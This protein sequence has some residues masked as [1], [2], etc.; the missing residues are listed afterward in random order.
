MNKSFPTTG[1]AGPARPSRPRRADRRAGALRRRVR[2]LHDLG[3]LGIARQRRARRPRA[4]RRPARPS[5]SSSA[6]PTDRVSPAN[7]AYPAPADR[8]ATGATNAAPEASER[9]ARRPRI[10]DRPSD[11]ACG[12]PAVS[13][14]ATAPPPATFRRNDS[15]H[16]PPERSG[17]GGAM[18]FA[19]T[20]GGFAGCRLLAVGV[21]SGRLSRRAAKGP[22]AA[23]GNP[24]RSR[25]TR[26][27]PA[28]SS[29]PTRPISTRRNWRSS[30]AICPT[31]SS[32]ACASR[33]SRSPKSI[34]ALIDELSPKLEA[35]K[36]RLN[37]LGPK[38]KDGQPEESADVAGTG[39]SGKPRSP[40]STR[41]SAS[42]ARSS[43]RPS[44]S[45][46][47]ISDRRRAVFTR[48]LFEQSAGI[49]SPDLWLDVAQALPR[50]FARLAPCSSD[51]LDRLRRKATAGALLLSGWRSAAAV[52]LY[53]GRRHVAP[54][55]VTRD[56]ATVEPARRSRLLAALA[57]AAPR[58]GA[59]DRRQLD[60]LD[61]LR[62]RSTSCRRASSRS[63][64]AVLRGLAF[65]AFVRA[66]VDAILAP[67]HASWRLLASRRSGRGAD[68]RASR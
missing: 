45:T 65:V 53:V 57:R 60:R 52:A 24:P 31:P 7:P 40:N 19:L 33:S 56:P 5:G 14:T 46:A 17:E 9:R 6:N 27:P 68:R 15:R 1:P 35:A 67:G 3:R 26:R 36:A 39:P 54:R 28:R 38:P 11:G 51:A 22:V 41:R 62:C 8:S 4:R 48:A 44:S 10:S 55:L 42:A 23:P 50:E 13:C 64:S 47:Q 29:T 2:R 58:R 18:D 12:A 16:G 32:S 63:S 30:G 49:L 59:G 61:R 43:S 21:R 20:S 34:R 25:S 37:Q 66:L